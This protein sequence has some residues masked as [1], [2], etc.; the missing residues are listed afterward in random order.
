MISCLFFV[1]ID[2][3]KFQ[4]KLSDIKDATGKKR[5]FAAGPSA[6]R[7]TYGGMTLQQ[8]K[9]VIQ[10][11]LESS[12]PKQPMPIPVGG[13]QFPIKPSDLKATG[14]NNKNK[15][16]PPPPSPKDLS[17]PPT[18]RG[19]RS[20]G[21]QRDSQS[22]Q[23]KRSPEIG[24][25]PRHNCPNSYANILPPSQARQ[26]INNGYKPSTPQDVYEDDD[27]DDQEVYVEPGK[28]ESAN[29]TYQNH[30]FD[31]P[32]KNPYANVNVDFIQDNSIYQNVTQQGTPPTPPRVKPRAKPKK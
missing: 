20:P 21:H 12:K 28:L 22:S 17:A 10:V 14:V 11:D 32:P 30:S 19:S 23:Q 8:M 26:Q 24:A 6:E 3:D 18:N 13:L 1:D 15:P 25:S 16:L 31:Q 29:H 27:E 5:M 7:H 4:K 2:F 9:E